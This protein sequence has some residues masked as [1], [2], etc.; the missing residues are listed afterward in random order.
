[1]GCVLVAVP[2]A[3]EVPLPSPLPPPLLV[4][5][6]LAVGRVVAASPVETTNRCCRRFH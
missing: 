2:P 1:M 3:A 4:L 6:L 5:L